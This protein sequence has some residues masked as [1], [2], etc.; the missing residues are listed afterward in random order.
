MVRSLFEMELHLE[1]GTLE[2]VTHQGRACS[3]SSMVCN[4]FG[5][6]GSES[7]YSKT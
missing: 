6:S 4:G 3:D 7:N 5:R 2:A 1:L